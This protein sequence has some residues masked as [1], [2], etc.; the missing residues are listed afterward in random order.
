M[1][2][3]GFQASLSGSELHALNHYPVP[4]KVRPKESKNVKEHWKILLEVSLVK[5]SQFIFS[6]SPYHTQGGS[7]TY[8]HFPNVLSQR[9]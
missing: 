5:R 8:G 2:E 9:W 1:A 3:P 6:K 7:K 4:M